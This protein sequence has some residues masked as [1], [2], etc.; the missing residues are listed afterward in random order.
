MISY[1]NDILGWRWTFRILGSAGCFMV[2]IAVIALWEPKSVREKRI[3]RMKGK[4]A[5]SILVSGYCV[6]ESQELL[7]IVARV[8]VCVHSLCVL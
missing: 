5:Y 1:I 2:P 4:R 7:V 8:W 3:S 6:R